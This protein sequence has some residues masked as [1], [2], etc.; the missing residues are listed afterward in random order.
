MTPCRHFEFVNRICCTSLRALF[1]S[2]CDSSPITL[3]VA[4][5]WDPNPRSGYFTIPRQE[6]VH[7]IDP[8]AWVLHTNAMTDGGPVGGGESQGIHNGT[9]VTGASSGGESSSTLSP[10]GAGA[11]LTPGMSMGTL[12]S[13][14]TSMPLGTSA[15]A[16]NMAA[17]LAATQHQQQQQ[18]SQP[19]QHM[20]AQLP[21]PQTSQLSRTSFYPIPNMMIPQ[22][23]AAH[24]SFESSTH[25]LFCVTFSLS[26]CLLINIQSPFFK[27]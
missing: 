23:Y 26:Y 20:V 12:T 14:Q 24:V 25:Y 19:E 16:F 27:D 18:H 3:V 4:K 10:S 15:A 8:R 11:C 21:H 17:L 5:C 13:G 1:V 6:P 2:R 22:A 7:P 9:P